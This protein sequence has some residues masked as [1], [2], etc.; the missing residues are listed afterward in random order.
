MLSRRSNYPSRGFSANA[1]DS[2]R[3][4]AR[5]RAMSRSPSTWLRRCGGG[6]RVLV[7]EREANDERILQGVVAADTR[8]GP[9][10][11][12]PAGRGVVVEDLR[13]S[14]DAAIVH[15]RS[16]DCDVAQGR[17]HEAAHIERI[18]R[19]FDHAGVWLWISAL[20]VEVVEA[21]V[22]KWRIKEWLARVVD[23]VAQIEADVTVKALELGTRKTKARPPGSASPRK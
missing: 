17:G 7:A 4:G 12:G 10:E 16:C 9:R 3:G 15:V 6:R 8:V 19:D 20:A 5:T 18:A 21:R 14:G 11:D 23:V 13:Q 2:S 22:A 1:A